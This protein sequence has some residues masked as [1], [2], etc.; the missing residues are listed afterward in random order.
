MQHQTLGT[1]SMR[2]CHHRTPPTRPSPPPH[3]PPPH[4]NSSTVDAGALYPLPQAQ[5]LVAACATLGS[6]TCYLLSYT[7]GRD[8]VT[9]RFPEA[10]A[11]FQKQASG[12]KDGYNL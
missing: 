3:E 5:A 10:V 9:R 6:G 12:Y 4:L 11:K 1:V 2:L 7:L 8:M